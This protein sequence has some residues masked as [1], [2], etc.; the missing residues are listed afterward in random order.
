MA[1]VRIR[2]RSKQDILGAVLRVSLKSVIACPTRDT[3]TTEFSS[4]GV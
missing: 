2:G 4:K 3:Q 1:Y